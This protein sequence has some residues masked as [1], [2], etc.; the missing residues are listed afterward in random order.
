MKE[1][2]MGEETFLVRVKIGKKI[3]FQM[4]SDKFLH[5]YIHEHLRVIYFHIALLWAWI[6]GVYIN[7]SMKMV[8]M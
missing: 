3:D 8:E 2:A 6:C 5:T 4:R 7:S 1:I